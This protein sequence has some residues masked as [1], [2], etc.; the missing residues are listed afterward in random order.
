MRNPLNRYYGQGDL[1]FI[2]FS[3]YARRPYLGSPNARNK[4][5]QILDEVRSRHKLQLLGYVVMP[6][7][8][9]LVISEPQT[10][11]PSLQILKQTVSRQ[12][13]GDAAAQTLRHLE[14]IFILRCGSLR[15]MTYSYRNATMGSTRMARLAGT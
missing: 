5:L 7:H 1:H 3:C 15:A 10:G 2:T 9:H 6:E 12:V 4:F 8:V 11:D 14:P 13:K